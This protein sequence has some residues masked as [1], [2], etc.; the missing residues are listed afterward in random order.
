MRGSGGA[1]KEPAAGRSVV[2]TAPGGSSSTGG[3]A[4]SSSSKRARRGP[5]GNLIVGEAVVFAVR[6]LGTTPEDSVFVQSSVSRGTVGQ[7]MRGS[8]STFRGQPIPGVTRFSATGGASIEPLPHPSA[9]NVAIRKS[10][11]WPPRQNRNLM[12]TGV[13]VF[14]GWAA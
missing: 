8:T 2:E 12:F 7:P 14:A 5:G 6:L 11:R 1:G 10:F 4:N 13:A 3:E 9:H